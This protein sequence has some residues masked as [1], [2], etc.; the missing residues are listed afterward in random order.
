ML[1][2]WAN[3]PGN[4]LAALGRKTGLSKSYMCDLVKNKGRTPSLP[5]AFAIEKATNG[6]VPVS[7]WNE[8]LE[9]YQ[10]EQKRAKP[11]DEAA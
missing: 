4:S 10:E 6:E 5:V 11:Q 2:K 1:E 3:K 8:R 7:Y 9:R